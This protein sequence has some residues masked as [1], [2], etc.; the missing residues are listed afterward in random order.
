MNSSREDSPDARK[1]V[2]SYSVSIKAGLSPDGKRRFGNTTTSAF[3]EA[4]TPAGV[5]SPQQ[6][7]SKT[8]AA[9][10]FTTSN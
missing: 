6:Q 7:L 1:S 5:R 3:G 9:G 2:K 10:M 4:S 8:T